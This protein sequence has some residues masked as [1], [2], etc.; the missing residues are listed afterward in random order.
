MTGTAQ[1]STEDRG[2]GGRL[3]LAS[4]GPLT[5]EQLA[6]QRRMRDEVVPWAREAGAAAATAEGI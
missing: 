5:E 6:T 4:H 2:R 3:P 1:P